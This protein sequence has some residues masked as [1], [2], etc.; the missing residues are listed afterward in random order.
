LL[1]CV[2]L[3]VGCGDEKAEQAEDAADADGWILEVI[4]ADKVT[5][6]RANAA[7][8]GKV[9]VLDC[10]ATWCG[11]CVA[12]F[13]HLHEAIK[14]RGEGVTLVSLSFDE[15]DALAKEAAAFLIEQDAWAEG[16]A[17]RAAEGSDAKDAVAAALSPNWDG[18]ALPAVFVYKPNGSIALEFTETR[19][20][21][22]DW[23][24]EITAAVDA[25]LTE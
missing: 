23:V 19:G 1:A 21:V 14:E 24:A 10:W 17:Y 5:D 4:D 6:L 11:S 3:L 7:A 9:L 22:K 16:T 8:Q 13:P 12:M 2:V 20:D 15:G 18:G 25:S